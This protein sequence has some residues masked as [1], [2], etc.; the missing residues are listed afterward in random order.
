[1]IRYFDSSA[2]AKRYVRAEGTTEVQKTNVVEIVP[3]IVE[4]VHELLGRH[5][6]RAADSLQL[7]AALYL[8]ER[9]GRPAEFVVYD[10]RLAEAARAEH[11]RAA[12]SVTAE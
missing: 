3:I 1:M 5:A 12:M 10:E 7:A 6:L 11:L 2:L 8:A 9:V 4:R